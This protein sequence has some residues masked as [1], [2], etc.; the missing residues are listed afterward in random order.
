MPGRTGKGRGPTPQLQLR[1]KMNRTKDEG[2]PSRLWRDWDDGRCK[3]RRKREDRVGRT[4]T[5]KTIRFAHQG[6]V[7]TEGKIKD[8]GTRDDE[9]IAE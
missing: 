3:D 5:G 7:K 8:R 6:D 1:G 4:D 2:R 9:S